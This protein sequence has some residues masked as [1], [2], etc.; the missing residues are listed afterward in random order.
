MSI[1]SDALCT[2]NGDTVGVRNFTAC[3]AMLG[4]MML[5]FLLVCFLLFSEEGPY[6]DVGLTPVGLT[7]FV[8][9]TPVS[10]I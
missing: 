5:A 4:I 1:S 7:L 2:T 8:G 6:S 3:V 10:R 9:L